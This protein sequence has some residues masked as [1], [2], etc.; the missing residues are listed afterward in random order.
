MIGKFSV[1]QMNI[2]IARTMCYLH[3]LLVEEMS[4]AMGTEVADPI[5]LVWIWM[6][7]SFLLLARLR[8]IDLRHVIPRQHLLVLSDPQLRTVHPVWNQSV[9]MRPMNFDPIHFVIFHSVIMLAFYSAINN[10]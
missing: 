3:H 10:L 8:S 4:V 1:C 2:S 5:F 9:A 6:E 7:W